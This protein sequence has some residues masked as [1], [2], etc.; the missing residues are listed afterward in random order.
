MTITGQYNARGGVRITFHDGGICEISDGKKVYSGSGV[1]ISATDADRLRSTSEDKQTD[2]SKQLISGT[3]YN[4]NGKRFIVF[5]HSKRTILLGPLR[6][7]SSKDSLDTLTQDTQQDK[8][9]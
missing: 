3:N 4:G 5:V 2:L 8:Q 6:E 7:S 1:I 9:S